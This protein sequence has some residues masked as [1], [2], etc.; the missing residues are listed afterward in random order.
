MVRIICACGA[1]PEIQPQARARLPGR[2]KVTLKELALRMRCS[3]CGEK[4]AE[5]VAVAR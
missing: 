4:A 5:I 3:S 2:L 1:G